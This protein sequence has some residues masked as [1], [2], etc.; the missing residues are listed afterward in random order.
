MVFDES[1]QI[2]GILLFAL[3][4]F[5]DFAHDLSGYDKFVFQVKE[6]GTSIGL[7]VYN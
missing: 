2:G 5:E 7:L 3:M 4:T 1:C 6:L